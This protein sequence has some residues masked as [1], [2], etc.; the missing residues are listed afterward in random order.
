MDWMAFLPPDRA[1]TTVQW[2][3]KCRRYFVTCEEKSQLIPGQNS[4]FA[5]LFDARMLASKPSQIVWGETLS[6]V[7]FGFY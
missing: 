2:C 1:G 6:R 5:V 4:V 3:Q 7:Y